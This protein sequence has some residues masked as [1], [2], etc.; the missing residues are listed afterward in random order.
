VNETTL[1]FLTPGWG[2]EYPSDIVNVTL[3]MHISKRS[4]P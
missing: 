2:Y 1:V 4:S 3:V